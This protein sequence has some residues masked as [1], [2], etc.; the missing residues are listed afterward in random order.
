MLCSTWKGD[1]EPIYIGDNDPSLEVGGARTSPSF[2]GREHSGQVSD[3]SRR[4]KK[5]SSLLQYSHAVS[6][7]LEAVA[8]P[9]F[10]FLVGPGC[11]DSGVL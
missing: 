4:L 9:L 11:P 5:S 7:P 2:S 10:I 1:P 6:V 8:L 3:P